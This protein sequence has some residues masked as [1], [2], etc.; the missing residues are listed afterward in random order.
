MG[1][2]DTLHA[3]RDT[4]D[5]W[6]TK[7]YSQL[8]VDYFVGD[9]MPPIPGVDVGDDYQVEILD[10]THSLATVRGGVLASVGDRRDPSLTQLDYWG[11]VV[12]R[13]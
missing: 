9:E 8:L 13:P 4:D 3:S 12:H 5:D 10:E 7:A 2:F 6:Q 11:N 1:M